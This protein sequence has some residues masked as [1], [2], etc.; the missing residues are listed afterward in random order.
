MSIVPL[1]CQRLCLGSNIYDNHKIK[2]HD[3][4]LLDTLLIEVYY[5]ALKNNAHSTYNVIIFSNAHF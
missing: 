3:D 2:Y 4:I 5:F 1:M